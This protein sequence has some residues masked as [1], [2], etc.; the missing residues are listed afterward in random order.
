MKKIYSILIA[1]IVGMFIS[2]A[3]TTIDLPV[4]QDNSI[5]SE[6][7]AAS[8]GAGDL[9]SGRTSRGDLRRA[10][11]SFN[12]S[13]IPANSTITDAQLIFSVTNMRGNG[14]YTIHRVTTDWGEGTSAGAG[15]G[16][17]GGPAQ[18]NDATWTQAQFNSVV[19]NTPG[20]DF[21]NTASASVPA[22]ASGLNF[23]S[24]ADLLMDLQDWYNS[25]EP[26]YGWM[27]IGDEINNQNAVRISSSE[28]T[29]A[30]PILRVTYSPTASVNGV[31]FENMVELYPNPSSGR[32]QVKVPATSSTTEYEFINSLG[33]VVNRSSRITGTGLHN[34]DLD[35][36]RGFYLIRIKQ[37]G[38][39]VTKKAVIK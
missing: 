24:S 13:G 26:N 1:F 38:Q 17:Q 25:V 35:L 8:S 15:A 4:L 11:I 37:A 9:F 20:G 3:Q 16:G 33:Q 23:I 18:G 19:W 31:S 27:I 10:L 34:F 6:D 28:S 29:G 39:T 32:F 5:F 22:L 30:A 21:I 36:K 2:T 12:L 14:A 7:N